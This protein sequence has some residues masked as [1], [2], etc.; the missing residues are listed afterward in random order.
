[1][2]PFPLDE[3]TWAAGLPPVDYFAG[4]ANYRNLVLSLYGEASVAAEDRTAVARA[5]AQSGA[6]TPAQPDERDSAGA[7]SEET[8]PGR[9][10]LFVLTEDWCGDSATTLPYIARLAE[11]LDLPARVFR[12]SANPAIKAWYVEGGTEHIPVVS[13]LQWTPEGGERGGAAV[14]TWREVM[15]WVERPAA[16]HGRV[17]GWLAEQPRFREL[18]ARKDEDPA[19]A[20]EYFSLYARLLRTMA[21]WYR[22]GLWSEIAREFAAA[23]GEDR[24]SG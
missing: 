15:R 4:L 5:L 7:T 10:R 8:P 16:A 3:S 22:G 11:A 1:M 20:K 14:G 12:Q 2:E 6:T 19:A 21:G 23:I 13:L 9:L 24:R 18:Y 17:E